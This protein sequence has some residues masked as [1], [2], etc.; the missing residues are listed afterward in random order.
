MNHILSWLRMTDWHMNTPAPYSFFH[1]SISVTGA[2]IAALLAL[3]LGAFYGG[4]G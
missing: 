4:I 1:I 2:A 3:I